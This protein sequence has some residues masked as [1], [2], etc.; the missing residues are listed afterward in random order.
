MSTIAFHD[1]SFIS[2]FYNSSFINQH[3]ISDFS[4]K[5]SY[6][7]VILINTTAGSSNFSVLYNS[8]MYDSYLMFCLKNLSIITLFTSSY[9]DIFSLVLLFSPELIVAF[10]DYFTTYYTNLS[11]TATVVSCFDSYTNNL[12]Y[13]FGEGLISFFMFFFF[14]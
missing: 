13:S 2:F 7:D 1:Y 3:L 4:T 10:G 9:Q 5:L 6:L 8:F 11:L 12:N 14:S